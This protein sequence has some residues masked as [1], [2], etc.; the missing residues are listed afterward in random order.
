[1][2]LIE[3]IQ[4]IS[5][6][7]SEDKKGDTIRTMIDKMGVAD[8]I[9]IMLKEEI[10]KDLSPILENLLNKMLVNKNQDIICRVKVKHPD[11]RTKLPHSDNTYLHYRVDIIFIGG[12]GTKHCPVTQAVQQRYDSLIDDMWN[13]VYDFTGKSI[14]IFAKIVNE[15]E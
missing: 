13:I 3:N 11:N 10:K 6:L 15:C 7:I 1:M 14:D 5:T 2:N 12:Y 8:T 9:K 4:R